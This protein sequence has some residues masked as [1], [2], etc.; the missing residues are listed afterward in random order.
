MFKMVV[1]AQLS[2]LA[3]AVT[4]FGQQTP[5]L[6]P[7][8]RKAVVALLALVLL[9][10]GLAVMIALGGRIVKRLARHRSGPSNPRDDSWYQKPLESQSTSDAPADDEH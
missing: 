7:P 6:P 2:A 1:M 10:I 4:I 3:H 5:R 9:G 8:V